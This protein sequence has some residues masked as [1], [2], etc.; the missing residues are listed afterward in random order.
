M[1][2]WI[3]IRLLPSHLNRF[4][5]IALHGRTDAGVCSF[6]RMCKSIKL[7]LAISINKLS[8]KFCGDMIKIYIWIEKNISISCV[9]LAIRFSQTCKFVNIP[10]C[11]M[12]QWTVV[13]LI[14]SS[15]NKL[16]QQTRLISSNK[17]FASKRSSTKSVNRKYLRCNNL[18]H[19]LL[20]DAISWP[21]RR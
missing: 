18:E 14:N 16:W 19:N 13:T 1:H 11:A 20:R 5:A 12:G 3:R 6:C 21:E 7:D 2:K 8:F 9:W 15:R 4:H 17:W 10:T